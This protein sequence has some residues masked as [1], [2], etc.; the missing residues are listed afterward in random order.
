MAK[1]LISCGADVSEVNN[2]RSLP[3]HLI[4]SC[5]D[6]S[7]KV[8]RQSKA[9]LCSDLITYCFQLVKL[10]LHHG[11]HVDQL[12]NENRN[13]LA[14]IK[15]RG[16]ADFSCLS[17]ISLKCIAA[18]AVT[19]Y[20]VPFLPTDLPKELVS[21]VEIHRPSPQSEDN[22]SH[23]PRSRGHRSHRNN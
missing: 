9:N 6:F 20:N 8:L 10:L 2:F 19:T 18:R 4:V 7:P 17:H 14:I 1:Y 5:D 16:N 22:R 15:A 13:P 23:S 12:D 21:F 11:S 3:L